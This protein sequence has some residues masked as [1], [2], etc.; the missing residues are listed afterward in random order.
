MFEWRA[1]VYDDC[2]AALIMT[3]LEAEKAERLLN[4]AFAIFIHFR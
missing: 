4:S 3:S 2:A 1:G